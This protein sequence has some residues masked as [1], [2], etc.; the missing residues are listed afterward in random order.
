MQDRVFTVAF[1][2][3]VEN[4]LLDSYLMLLLMSMVMVKFAVAIACWLR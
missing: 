4:T 2:G 1:V 3:K